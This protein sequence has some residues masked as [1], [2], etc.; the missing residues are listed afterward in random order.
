MADLRGT[1][2]DGT[3]ENKLLY[4]LSKARLQTSAHPIRNAIRSLLVKEHSV[5][6]SAQRR[7]AVAV[8]LAPSGS[9]HRGNLHVLGQISY[10][11]LKLD[12]T[13]AFRARSRRKGTWSRNHAVCYRPDFSPRFE[14]MVS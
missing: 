3:T 14:R 7:R 6:L 2:H 5:S 10:L 8:L 12:G 9:S 1:G 11:Y 13:Y 4:V